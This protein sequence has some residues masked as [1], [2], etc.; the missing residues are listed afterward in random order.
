MTWMM[1]WFIRQEIKIGNA[2]SENTEKI[3][4]DTLS[5]CDYEVD[6]SEDLVCS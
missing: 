1:S 4:L 6:H 5:L 3:D 2:Y